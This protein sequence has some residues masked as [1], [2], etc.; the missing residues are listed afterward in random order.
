MRTS[1]TLILFS[2]SPQICR[3]KTRMWPNLSHRE[4]L[5]LHKMLTQNIARKLKSSNKFKLVIYTTHSQSNFC[6]YPRQLKIKKQQGINLGARM[7]NAIAEELKYSQRV[8]LIG[9]DSLDFTPEV[10][11]RALDKLNS[12]KDI[13]IGPTHDGGYLL[14]G[15]RKQNSFLFENVAWSTSSVLDNT[16]KAA[17]IYNK[18]LHL[19]EAMSD[20]DTINDLNAL[21]R[22]TLLPHWAQSLAS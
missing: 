12:N 19:L 14:V 9:S 6:L 8:V 10:I 4:C 15:M 13:V 17:D 7:Q 11:H 3:V 16:I 21:S 20:L 22:Q 18:N 1:S 5:Y 2:K